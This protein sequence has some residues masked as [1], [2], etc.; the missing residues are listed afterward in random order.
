MDER[1]DGR[2][3]SGDSVPLCGQW[4][5]RVISFPIPHAHTDSYAM[6]LSPWR[7][8]VHAEMGTSARRENA[9]LGDGDGA[10]SM[11][12]AQCAS[13]CTIYGEEFI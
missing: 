7:A 6:R 4:R 1:I 8:L 3:T 11:C 9:M 13:A 2:P 5:G 10:L 12:V